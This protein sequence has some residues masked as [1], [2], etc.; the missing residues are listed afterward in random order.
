MLTEYPFNMSNLSLQRGSLTARTSSALRWSLMIFHGWIIDETKFEALHMKPSLKQR[1]RTSGAWSRVLL[2]AV[3][4]TE[5]LINLRTCLHDFFQVFI[6]CCALLV[7]AFSVNAASW[8][9]VELHLGSATWDL[10]SRFNCRLILKC[11]RKQRVDFKNHTLI[12]FSFG[13]LLF[14]NNLL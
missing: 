9:L 10:V 2:F 7:L 5:T 12:L 3:P 8:D 11:W 1:Q 14:Q 13:R 4:N 6:W